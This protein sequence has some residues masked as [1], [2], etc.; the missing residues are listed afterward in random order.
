MTNIPEDRVLF[1]LLYLL[2]TL[3]MSFRSRRYLLGVSRIFAGY[4]N[5]KGHLLLLECF[6]GK[7]DLRWFRQHSKSLQRTVK[8]CV[9]FVYAYLT[10]KKYTAM[11]TGIALTNFFIVKCQNGGY[12][13]SE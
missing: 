3:K 6:K 11:K 1:D 9:L 13:F 12:F 10:F 4:F 7:S 5:I 2:D 8:G